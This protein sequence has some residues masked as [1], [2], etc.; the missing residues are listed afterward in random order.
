MEDQGLP[1][2]VF[3]IQK[4]RKKERRK[5]NKCIYTSEYPFLLT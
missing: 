3:E 5:C 2:E 1:E 4:K